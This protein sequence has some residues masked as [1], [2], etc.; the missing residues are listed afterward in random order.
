M[1]VVFTGSW[2][3]LTRRRAQISKFSPDA[4]SL[5][6]LRKGSTHTP[7]KRLCHDAFAPNENWYRTIKT[8]ERKKM[9]EK[10]SKKFV[11]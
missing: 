1:V 7:N 2:R 10:K 8:R 6:I 9:R 4:A 3:M 11:H 5:N